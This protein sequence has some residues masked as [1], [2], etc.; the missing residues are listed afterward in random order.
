MR[1]FPHRRE[2]GVSRDDLLTI[3][4]LPWLAFTSYATTRRPKGDCIPLLAIGK[5]EEAGDAYHLPFFV[6]FHHALADGLHI[7]RFVKYIEDEALTLAG[8]LG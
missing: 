2:A 6:N 1:D 3:S 7:A 8:S 4:I 5:V